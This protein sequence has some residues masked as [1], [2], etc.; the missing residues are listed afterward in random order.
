MGRRSAIL[1]AFAGMLATTGVAA[2]DAPP[3]KIAG[4]TIGA[5]AAQIV[6]TLAHHGFQ[7]LQSP[8][9]GR[10]VDPGGKRDARR[11][12]YRRRDGHVLRVG[13]SDAEPVSIASLGY[14]MGRDLDTYGAIRRHLRGLYGAPDARYG[15]E[16]NVRVSVWEIE[17]DSQTLAGIPTLGITLTKDPIE[18]HSLRIVQFVRRPGFHASPASPRAAR[19][20]ASQD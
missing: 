3:L 7:P 19:A 15:S 13:L 1:L 12:S 5:P 8:Y 2:S 14:E 18:G 10:A 20:S 16:E 4:L 11:L 9:S 6:A 17:G